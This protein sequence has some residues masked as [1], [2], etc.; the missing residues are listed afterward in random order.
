MSNKHEM[1]WASEEF[2]NANLGDKRL[3]RRLM[4]I[5][6]SFSESPESPINQACENWGD[7]KAAYRFF[8][9]DKVKESEISVVHYHKTVGRASKHKTILAI[10]D[11]SYIIY[12]KHPKTKGLGKIAMH[13]GK[14]VKEIFT[15]GLVMHTCLAVNTKGLPLGLLHQNIFPRVLHDESKNSTK[16]RDILPVEEK[17]S[18]RWIEA[19]SK[20]KELMSDFEVIT[21]CDREGDFYDFFRTAN[22]LEAKTLVRASVNR[23]VNK[24]ARYATRDVI[25]LWDHISMMPEAGTFELNIPKH[26]KKAART[27]TVTVKFGSYKFNPPVNHIKHR[28]E[29][30]PDLDMN[31]IY[32]F[33]SNPPTGVDAIEWMLLTNF[34]INSFTDALEKIKWYCL[35]WRIEMFFKVLK[36][37]LKVEDCRLGSANRLAK[38]LAIMSIIAWRLFMITLLGRTDPNKPCTDLITEHEWKV[39]FLKV[40]KNKELPEEIPSVGEVV[41]WIARLGGFLARKGDG[42][43]GTITLW[44]GWK[45]LADLTDGWQI[46]QGHNF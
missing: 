17:E 26:E 2:E 11:T 24:K 43:P 27:A 36:S 12:T 42:F 41:I 45:R 14:H 8:K 7:S 38:Y 5:C 32:V 4:T 29:K 33:E 10:Q 16:H 34:P 39:L 30:L 28:T 9:N 13:K 31:A 40:N 15:K 3:N 37:G 25:K 35:R 20:T 44:R 18:Y 22:Q 21:V 6:D 23:I 46:A 19:L 1:S